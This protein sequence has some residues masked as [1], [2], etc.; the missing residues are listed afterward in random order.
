MNTRLQSVPPAAGQTAQAGRVQ[1]LPLRLA[2]VLAAVTAVACLANLLVPDLLSGTA[3]MNGSARGTSL[4]ALVVAVPL[5]A[6]CSWRAHLGSTHALVITTGATA[7]LLYNSVLFLFATPF[8]QAFLLYVAML[9]LAAWSLVGLSLALWSR[10]D[11]LATDVPRWVAGYV[12]LVVALNAI[13]WLARVIPATLDEDPTAWLAD[14]GLTTNPVITQ[15]L[16]LW[17]PLMAW[18]G[19][20]VWTSRPSPVALAA[21]GLV[22]WVVESLGIAADQWW[23]HQADPSSA[24]ASWEAVPMF[25]SLA[26]VA[27]LP[28]L[29]LF[30][31]IPDGL[32]DHA[33]QR[34]GGRHGR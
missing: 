20:G 12:W 29:R 26:L 23:G 2:N 3:V 14:T 6:V 16:A 13:A 8:N 17:L 18:L 1:I 7:Y 32:D 33:D 24:W 10:V 5:L 19:W 27:L 11:E 28:T 9:G 31:A 4:V 34:R 15:D 30:Q 25:L 22:F 21:A